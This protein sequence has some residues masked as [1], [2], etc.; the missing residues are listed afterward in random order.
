MIAACHAPEERG[1]VQGINDFA[2]F[3]MVGHRLASLR[4][5]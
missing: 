5:G 1:R 4:A 3:G 2:V